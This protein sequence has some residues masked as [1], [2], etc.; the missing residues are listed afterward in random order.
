MPPKRP[1]TPEERELDKKS[2]ELGSLEKQLVE[3]ELE[4]ET[5]R[6]GL[7]NFEKKYQDATQLRY[8]ML[9]ELH[10]RISQ[11]RASKNNNAPT[12]Q[13]AMSA[14]AGHMAMPS[15]PGGAAAPKRKPRKGDSKKEAAGAGAASGF[16]PSEELKKLYREVAKTIHP[17]LA[18]EEQERAHRHVFMTRANEAYEAN[19][20]EKL[21]KVLTDWHHSPESVR[22]KDAASEL[23]RAIRKIA[24]CEDRL[25]QIETDMGKLETAGIFGIKMLAEEAARQWTA[26]FNPRSVT[27]EDFVH[28]YEAAFVPRGDGDAE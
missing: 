23:I 16:N 21:A 20:A 27:V 1:P 15:V 3:R 13:A 10:F 18:D 17:D 26:A 5:M 7:I 14:I 2:S 4:L 6:G 11:L 9:D 22:G 25:V 19:D 12:A 8:A 24:R 28:L